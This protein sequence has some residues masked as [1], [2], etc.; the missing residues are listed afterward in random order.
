MII[1][2]GSDA[3][4]YHRPFATIALIAIN[5]LVYLVLPKDAYE[6]YVLVLGHG[7]H[8][9]QWLT[10]NFLHTGV[11]H[12]AGNMIFLWT[13]G[14]VVEGKLGWWRFT[15]VYVL[16]GVLESGAMQMLVHSE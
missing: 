1:P 6:G 9:V 10:N 4:L 8:P 5:V 13:F 16:L 3:P 14:L 2:L 11:F 7:V 15:L 12:L